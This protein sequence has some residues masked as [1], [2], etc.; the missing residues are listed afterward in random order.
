MKKCI[1]V[2]IVLVLALALVACEQKIDSE[3]N[4]TVPL[5]NEY[6]EVYVSDAV[7]AEWYAPL[8]K[9]LSNQEESYGNP[10]DGIIGY[11]PPR[12]DDPSIAA[13]C[14]M[15]LFDVNLDG[16]PELLLNLG[17]G[18]AGNDYFY[19]Y[20]IFTGEN[21][22]TINGGGS[23]AWA[24][25]YD[26]ENNKYITIGR[27]D[28][29]SGDSGSRH[30]VKTIIYDENNH[31]YRE[32]SLFFSSYEYDKIERVDE[33]GDF[34]GIDIE[35]AD[36]SF[37]VNGESSEF[38]NYHYEITEFYQKHCLV[39]YTGIKLFYWSDVSDEDD[40]YQERAEKMANMLLYGSEQKFIKEQR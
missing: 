5:S 3:S 7:K 33:N 37:G 28:W 4:N 21:I 10:Q 15:G 9:L 30:F 39:P 8:V 40:S 19:V 38:Q 18:S 23:E 14:D 20:D 12:P 17:G 22:G 29:R 27:Y 1:L 26:V 16:V 35:I 25:Y 24:V 13:G 2:F 31:E 11:E 32:K 6:Q 34:S 36:V